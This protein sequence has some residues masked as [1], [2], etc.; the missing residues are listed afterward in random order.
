MIDICQI[1]LTVPPLNKSKPSTGKDGYTSPSVI[2][3]F[4][5][6]LR[7]IDFMRNFI[8]D[9]FDMPDKQMENLIGFLRQNGGKLSKRALDK[10]FEALTDDE[11]MLLENKYQKVFS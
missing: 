8:Q 7:I 4:E 1:N 9:H 3:F 10:E 2:D 6:W 5:L 11:V